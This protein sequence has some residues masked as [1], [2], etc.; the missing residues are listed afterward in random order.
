MPDYGFRETVSGG[1]EGEEA[2][3][4]WPAVS[5]GTTTAGLVGGFL[6]LLLAGLIGFTLRHIGRT[7]ETITG[8]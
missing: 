1:D 8:A 2:E 5:A 4:V 6:T 3:E 7:R